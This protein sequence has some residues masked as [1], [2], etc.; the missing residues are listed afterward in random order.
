MQKLSFPFSKLLV[1]LMWCANTAC[2]RYFVPETK[3]GQSVAVSDTVRVPDNLV[4][5]RVA[6]YIKPYHDSLDAGMN[7]VLIR[8]AKRL[9]KGQPESGMGNLLCDL[10]REMGAQKYGKPIEVALANSGGIRTE[11]QAGDIT[12][13]NVYEVMPF[14][15][16]LVVLTLSGVQMKA[17]VEEFAKRK[18]PQSGMKVVIENT[19]NQ[20]LEI[21]IGGQ[22]IDPQ[23]TYTLITSDYVANSSDYAAV[24]K[25]PV[26]YEVLNYLM[27]DAILD[28]LRLKGQQKIILDPQKDGRT[29]VR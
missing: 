12:T 14:D 15:N 8:S 19:T 29:S 9:A 11:W 17:F 20:V 27:R 5:E 28:Y 6:A 26:S 7:T 10:F 25:K 23:K 4:S 2:Q 1:I 21:A 22:P 18:D 3:K 24:F 16:A 13:G